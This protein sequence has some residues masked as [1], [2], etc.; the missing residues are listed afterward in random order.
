MTVVPYSRQ[1]ISDADIAAVVETLQS[2]FLTQGPAVPKFEEAFAAV[3]SVA[4][5]VAVANATVGLHLA[6]LALGLRKGDLLW[7]SPNSFV[8]SANCALYCGADVDFV[9]I[10]PITRNMSVEQL[11]DKLKRGA[12]EGRLPKV[13]VPVDFAGLP[14]DLAAM[15]EL[16]DRYGF[17]LLEDASHAVGASLGGVPV[18]SRYADITV[19][20]FHP[21]KIVTTGEGGLCVTQDEK[22]AARLRLLR[23]HGITRDPELMAGAAEGPWYYE[24]IDLGYNYRLTDL[25]AALGFSQLQRLPELHAAREHRARRY[26][27]L[28]APL[29]LRLPARLD[30]RIS[31]HHLYVVEID[32]ERSNADRAEVFSA[33][34]AD[35]I[36]ANVHYIPI[37]LQPHYRARG[38]SRGDFPNAEA[39]YRQAITI[40]LFPAM[41]DTEQD[42]VVES[43]RRALAE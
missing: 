32:R 22:L 3:H 36:G 27:A 18:G 25:Q 34:R 20:S 33:L 26:D 31:A 29:P 37:H 30:D 41:T 16:A 7:T 14:C 11:A 24:Q 15:R 40:P 4:F 38:F 17:A 5:G 13:V 1:S 2:D 43:L 28:L 23:T 12:R 19:F 21:V 9:D 6:C 35:G 42:R 39:Y 10:D 8:A